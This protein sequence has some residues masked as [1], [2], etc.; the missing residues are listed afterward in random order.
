MGPQSSAHV[1]VLLKDNSIK[2]VDYVNETNCCTT[3]TIHD[4]CKLFRLSPNGRYMLTAGDKG[5]IVVY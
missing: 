3:E 5:D 4:T 2:M 1:L